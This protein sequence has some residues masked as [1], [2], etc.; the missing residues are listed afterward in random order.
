LAAGP[1][2]QTAERFM[3]WEA[4]HAE[5]AR[6]DAE[7]GEL[8]RERPSMDELRE[9][10]RQSWDKYYQRAVAR[11]EKFISGGAVNADYFSRLERA[12]VDK[13]LVL[14]P[15]ALCEDAL[16]ALSAGGYSGLPEAERKKESTSLQKKKSKIAAEMEEL[17]PPEVFTKR[18]P[19]SGAMINA[20]AAFFDSWRQL[21]TYTATDC[22]YRGIELK[23]ADPETIKA[24]AVLG[25]SGLRSR[26]ARMAAFVP[27]KQII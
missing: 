26:S 27:P 18:D 6:I 12:A 25:L 11:M 16:D 8:A 15:W 13:Q 14:V 22:C 9:N 5:L 19:H 23:Q 4:K 7:L 1:L 10:V 21:Q 24:H 20:A 3:R 2:S 17:L